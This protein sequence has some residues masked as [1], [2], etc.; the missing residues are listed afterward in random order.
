M[1]F[2]SLILTVLSFVAIAQASA[3]VPPQF[4]ERGVM[5]RCPRGTAKGDHDEDGRLHDESMSNIQLYDALSN[6][7]II[8]DCR[9]NEE[10]CS[11]SC[12][13]IRGHCR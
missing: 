3:I 12:E 6:A 10:C 9:I 11:R 5:A 1:Q 8:V 13:T 7:K 4:L 2:S